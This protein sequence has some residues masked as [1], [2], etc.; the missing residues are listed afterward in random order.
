MLCE[1]GGVCSKAASSS[2]SPMSVSQTRNVEAGFLDCPMPLG[3]RNEGQP[4]TL[5]SRS[6]C[7]IADVRPNPIYANWKSS[8]RPLATS[9]R[10]PIVTIP[11]PTMT[12]IGI[13]M[14]L[15]TAYLGPG[16]KFSTKYVWSRRQI[17]SGGFFR[18]CS[19]NHP[20]RPCRPANEPLFSRPLSASTVRKKRWSGMGYLTSV[21]CP[22]AALSR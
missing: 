1:R 11:H 2:K 8:K 12:E 18:C 13:E 19:S 7:T 17:P 21:D 3:C 5:C 16:S 14:Y 20:S 6:A 10:R 9:S 15:Q 22:F 4:S